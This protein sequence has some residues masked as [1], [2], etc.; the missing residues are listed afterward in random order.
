VQSDERRFGMSSRAVVATLVLSKSFG[1]VIR[2]QAEHSDSLHSLQILRLLKPQESEVR[3]EANES[4]QQVG[5][6]PFFLSSNASA[7]LSNKQ[8]DRRIL[9]VLASRGST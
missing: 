9:R 5:E 7:E 6:F 8:G 2:C 4:P 3:S 1:Y